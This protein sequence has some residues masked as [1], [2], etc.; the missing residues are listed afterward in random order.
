MTMLMPRMSKK[1]LRSFLAVIALLLFVAFAALCFWPRAA[2]PTYEGRT[3]E[4]WLRP[5]HW[6]ENEVRSRRA[7][8]ALG[9]KAEAPLKTVLRLRTPNAEVWLCRKIPF[10]FPLLQG[11]LQN[12]SLKN[13]A[14]ACIEGPGSVGDALI[15]DVIRLVED[16]QEFM[17]TRLRALRC[18]HPRMGDHSSIEEA[19]VRLSADPTLGAQASLMLAGLRKQKDEKELRRVRR[20]MDARA[21]PPRSVGGVPFTNRLFSPEESFKLAR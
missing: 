3:V 8:S 7:I 20:L 6:E 9:Q 12:T 5:V 16:R 21:A 4:E 18:L 10:A 19:L 15:P 14:L 17:E 2:Q 1:A 13:N 11:G